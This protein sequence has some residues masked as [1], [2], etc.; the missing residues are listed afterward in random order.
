[1]LT[2][3][4][5]IIIIRIKLWSGCTAKDQFCSTQS[6]ADSSA[7]AEKLHQN[8]ISPNALEFSLS[9]SLFFFFFFFPSF[10]LSSR[11]PADTIMISSLLFFLFLFSLPSFSRHHTFF[12][13]FFLFFFKLQQWRFL[14]FFL[15]FFFIFSGDFPVPEPFFLV[16]RVIKS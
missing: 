3:L 8:I 4:F 5:E 14:L 16:F 12:P 9:L 10:P 1:M 6:L 11:L 15:F 7:K 2:I 13:L